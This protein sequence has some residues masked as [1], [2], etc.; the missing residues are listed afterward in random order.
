MFL[1]LHS[2]LGRVLAIQ[3]VVDA[4]FDFDVIFDV[5]DQIRVFE[6][7]VSSLGL[8]WVGFL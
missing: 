8:M 6:V 5:E 2:T 7:L 1:H 3:P 4:V